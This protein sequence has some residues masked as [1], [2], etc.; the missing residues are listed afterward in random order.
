LSRLRRRRRSKT[1]KS[2]ANHGLR[3][4]LHRKRSQFK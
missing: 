2:K 3:P 4:T 1:A